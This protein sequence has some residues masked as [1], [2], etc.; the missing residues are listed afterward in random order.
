[1]GRCA[2]TLVI[3]GEGPLEAALRA[4]VAE[5]R[6]D[7]PRAVRRPRRRRRPAGVLPGLRR[8]SSC[9]RSLGPKRSASSRSRR[10]RPGGRSSART[11]RPACRGSIR[12]A[13]AVSSC[14]RA[15]PRRSAMRSRGW[16]KTRRCGGAWAAGAPRAPTMF[17][18]ERMVAAFR[19]LIDT[20]RADRRRAARRASSAREARD[21][22]R[23]RLLDVV[24]VR[25]RPD[26][27]PRRCGR[28]IAAAIKLDT[29]GPVFF[30]AGARRRGRTHLRA[31]KFRSMI[32][33]AERDVGPMQ[34]AARRSARHAR[35]PR[36]ARDG[37]GRAAA[38]VEHLSRRHELRRSAR[39][40]AGRDRRRYR[41][42]RRCRSRRFPASP[43]GRRCRPG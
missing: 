6:P 41:R 9:R 26:R 16:S 28:S 19:G 23:K 12:T 18:R 29:P 15:T 32:A 42:P 3:V 10:W 24:A 7:R 27:C 40:A 17:S 5:R 21:D 2:G 22:A 1:M 33:D 43:T 31:L 39:A 30:T 25:R 34:A 20:C 13:S 8:R 4:L 35:R 14:R 37:D 36:A 11:C 38:A